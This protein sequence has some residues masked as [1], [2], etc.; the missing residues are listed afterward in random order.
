M[1]LWPFSNLRVAWNNV[2]IVDPLVTVPLTVLVLLAWR[3]KRRVFARAAMGWVVAYL[4]LG[5]VARERAET[6][7]AALAA[8][9]GHEP[10]RLEV[11]PSFANLLL[12]KSIYE[13]EDRY[14]VDAV[15]LGLLGDPVVYE[16]APVAT[17]DLERDFPWLDPRSQQGEDVG[18]FRWF[19]QGFVA[20]DPR[21]P[22]RIGDVRYSLL[23]NDVS[24][25][26]AI[27]LDEE[28]GPDA[29]VGYLNDR[30]RD[31]DLLERFGRMLR[32]EPL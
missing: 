11:K 22:E 21:H 18:R 24:S 29:H 12:W 31:P 15:R 2:S 13:A 16:G 1:L 8:G 9:R 20:V 25:L 19:S 4:L 23:P 7:A 5:V 27:T 6:H 30:S 32:G 10:A 28:A 3:K 17:L 14:Y 26:W